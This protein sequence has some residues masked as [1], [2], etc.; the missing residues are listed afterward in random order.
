MA[1]QKLS[2]YYAIKKVVELLNKSEVKIKND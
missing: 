2:L 1:K